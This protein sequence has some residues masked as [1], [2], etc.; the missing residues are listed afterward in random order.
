MGGGGVEEAGGGGCGEVLEGGSGGEGV[1]VV[2]GELV[3]VLHGVWVVVGVGNG[4]GG[5]FKVLEGQ[6][7]R[8]ELEV[9]PGG[10]VVCSGCVVGIEREIEI[11]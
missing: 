3:S 2:Q 9:G 7:G 1:E 11:E 4:D 6:G 10:G 5:D 8:V